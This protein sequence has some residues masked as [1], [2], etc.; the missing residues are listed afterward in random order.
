M[1]IVLSEDQQDILKA[2]SSG[3]NVFI[4]GPG[5]CGKSFIIQKIVD[6]CKQLNKNVQVCATTGCASILLKCSAKTIHSWS[7]IGISKM[8]DHAI[9]TKIMM[10]AKKRKNWREVEILIIDEVSMMSQSLFQLLNHIG[11]RIRKNAKPFGGIQLICSG[12]FFQLPPVGNKNDPE[13]G[14]FCFESELWDTVFD[15]Q[16]LLDKL[17]RQTDPEYINILHEIREGHL[18]KKSYEL[19]STRVRKKEELTDELY[20]YAVYL[21]PIKKQ[22]LEMNQTNLHKIKEPEYRFEAETKYQAQT[23]I[24]THKP[25]SNPVKLSKPQIKTETDYLLKNALFDTTL[26]LKKGCKVMCIV[27]LDMDNGIFNGSIGEIID[28]KYDIDTDKEKGMVLQHE[29]LSTLKSQPYPL[30]KFK[31]GYTKLIRPYEWKS[32]TVNGLTVKQIPIILAWGITIHKSQGST[33]ENAIID[34]GKS[35]FENGQTYV[36]LSRVKS[37]QGLYLTDFQP[38]KIRANSKVKTF[39]ERFYEDDDEDEDDHL[40]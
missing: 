24:H 2:V 22:A 14:L 7:G 15:E 11:Q 12:D 21:L 5:G 17:F 10:N 26:V 39:Y 25:E 32:E 38:S 18:S 16:I 34:L 13:S 23:S 3:K 27:N 4:T 31:N 19:L 6:Q 20:K 36:A 35:V 8:D 29:T 37:L 9:T 1:T 30:V 33:L 28:F 40:K